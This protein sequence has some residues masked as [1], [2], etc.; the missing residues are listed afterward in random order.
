[1]NIW[2]DIDQ[3][4]IKDI[5]FY[6]PIQN[7]IAN[8]KHFYKV[9]Y[10]IEMFTLN[11]L[12]IKVDV[13]DLQIVKENLY[14]VQFVVDPLFLD[15]LKLFEMGILDHFNHI[16]NKKII[17]SFNKFT[18]KLVYNTTNSSIN[19]ALRI[20]GIWE[21]DAQIGITYKLTIN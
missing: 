5:S 17:Y 12:I 21:S 19:I 9:L 1:M 10:N 7:K 18:N 11:T 4:N 6:K 2:L 14:R 13:K 3:I 15:K 16:T 20:S 8:Y